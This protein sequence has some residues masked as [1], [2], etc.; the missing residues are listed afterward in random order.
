[1]NNHQFFVHLLC[2]WCHKGEVLSDGKA[3]ITISV[4]CPICGRYYTGDLDAIKTERSAACKRQ[5]RKK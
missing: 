2:P 5:G 3:K 4:C 1:M